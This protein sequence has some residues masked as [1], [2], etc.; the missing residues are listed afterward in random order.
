MYNGLLFS[1]QEKKVLPYATTWVNLEDMMLSELR[2]A[3]K[4]QYRGFYLYEVSS[5]AKCT[6]AEN[7]IAV[8]R[9]WVV[10][11]MESCFQQV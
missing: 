9:G 4:D 10:G 3:Q 7:K 8:A 11:E 5:V 6:K 1:F 2:Q